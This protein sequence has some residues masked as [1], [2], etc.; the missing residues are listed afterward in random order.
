MATGLSRQGW[1]HPRR[2]VEEVRHYIM[3]EDVTVSRPRG[4]GRWALRVQPRMLSHQIPIGSWLRSTSKASLEQAAIP[5]TY[6]Y[7]ELFC[8]LFY[9]N[10]TS[11]LSKQTTHCDPTDIHTTLRP[12][13]TPHPSVFVCVLLPGGPFPPPSTSSGSVQA[14]E[15]TWAP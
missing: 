7:D 15:F 3:T 5:L 13:R 14:P 12:H 9:R 2:L 4:Q 11:Y 1:L 6:I 10:S 8:L